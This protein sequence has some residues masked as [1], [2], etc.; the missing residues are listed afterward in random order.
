MNDSFKFNSVILG[1]LTQESIINARN[2]AFINQPGGNLLYAAYGFHLW[3]GCAGLISQVGCNYPQDWISILAKRGFDITG[4]TRKQEDID[5]RRFYAI[6][7]DQIHIDN[8]QKYFSDLSLPFP[9]DLLGYSSD[10]T[11]LDNRKNLSIF[12]I[13]TDDIPSEYLDAGFLLVCPL[14]FLTHSLI[15]PF[16]RSKTGCEVIIHPSRSY[17]HSSF[18]YDFPPVVRGASAMIASEENLLNLFLGKLDDIWEIAEAIADFGVQ[19]VVILRKGQ[20]YLLYSG[21]NH[22]R[23]AFPTYPS[24]AV[25]PIGVES[26]FCGGFFAGYVNH[27][28]PVQAVQMG[29]VT[30]S[31]KIQGSTPYYL[32]D[33][34]PELA[35][36]RLEVLKDQVREC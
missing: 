28:D 22:K 10:Q 18:Y 4:I 8:P 20:G 15:P 33:T 19:N 25:D 13:K 26:A 5:A 7:G 6:Q 12:T 1:R 31:I 14:D 3:G 29:S 9:R 24:E 16:F 30:A 17:L 34:L 2:E 35:Y 11:R 21:Y 27:L 32:L 23:M 36:A